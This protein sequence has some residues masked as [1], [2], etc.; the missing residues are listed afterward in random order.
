[1]GEGG[2]RAWVTREGMVGIRKALIWGEK[3]A[4]VLGECEMVRCMIRKGK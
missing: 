2:G 1:M 4:Y 3:T